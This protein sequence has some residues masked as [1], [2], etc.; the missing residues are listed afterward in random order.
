MRFLGES[1]VQHLSVAKVGPL[2]T[3][4]FPKNIIWRVVT[5]FKLN[6]IIKR[7]GCTYEKL[8]YYEGTS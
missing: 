8:A 6:G 4:V 5:T 7:E 2:S 3:Q 1:P